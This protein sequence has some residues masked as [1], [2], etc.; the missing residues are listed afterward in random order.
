MGMPLV[1]CV[2]ATKNR[3]RFI[4]QAL[5]CFQ[6][7][8]YANAELI[9]VDD[10]DRPVGSLCRDVPGVRYLRLT[11]PSVQGTKI[12]L[13]IEAARGEWIQ[14][15]DDDDYYAPA[16]LATSARNRPASDFAGTIVTRC[17]FLL[18]MRGRKEVWHSGH[19]WNTGGSLFFHR[20]LWKTQPFR[21]VNQSVDTHLLR[22]LRPEIKRI[23]DV[24]QYIVVRHGTNTWNWGIAEGV[25][26]SV[27]QYFAGRAIYTKTLE[28]LVPARDAADYRKL[29]R[30]G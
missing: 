30:Q 7:R 18:T 3:R 2:M 16:F 25:R 20:S 6:R 28:E 13:G 15:L 17:C 12:N 14:K 26:M 4:P 5:R 27:E 29:L 21:D 10:G 24:E 11:Q 22:D 23:C 19:G 9:L 1:S 8:T